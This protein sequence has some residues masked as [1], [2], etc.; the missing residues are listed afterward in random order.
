MSVTV[1]PLATDQDVPP[2]AAVEPIVRLAVRILNPATGGLYWSRG[3]GFLVD[4]FSDLVV[5]AAHV[6]APVSAR[7]AVEVAVL[8]WTAGGAGAPWR[9]WATG[10]A[11]DAQGADVA[12]L[13][14]PSPVQTAWAMPVRP[15]TGAA[16]GHLYGYTDRASFDARRM[17]VLPLRL[18]PRASWIVFDQGSGAPGLSGGAVLANPGAGEVVGC[19][20]GTASVDGTQVAVATP[21]S[22]GEL[23][24]LAAFV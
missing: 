17:A 16:A 6:V 7:R 18:A 5:T 21:V 13:R 4:D 19:Y 22:S 12:V 24:R 23:Q 9:L 2:G 3:C 14:L 11:F 20:H 1:L 10:A 8:G 15:L